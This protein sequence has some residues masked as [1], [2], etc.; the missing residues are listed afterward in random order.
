MKTIMMMMM[1]LMMM[2]LMMM[3]M[4]ITMII[5]VMRMLLMT[6]MT[7]MTR[8]DASNVFYIQ[9]G[10]TVEQFWFKH[11]EGAIG[12]CIFLVVIFF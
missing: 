9:I 5:T 12:W 7:T 11:V 10:E 3:V 8:D 1:M 6:T 2:M 4:M